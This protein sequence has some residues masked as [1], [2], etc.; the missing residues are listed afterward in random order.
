M[1]NVCIGLFDSVLRIPTAAIDWAVLLTQLV[2]AGVIDLSN[3]TE[4][5]TTLQDML[6]TLLHATLIMDGQSDRGEESRKYH[7]IL[8][9]KLKKE[10]AERKS[11]PSILCIKQLLPLP[12]LTSEFVTCE[13][14][15]TLTD[16]KGNKISGFDSNDKKQGH[17]LHD[18]QRVSPWEILE[19]HKTAAPLSW[20]WFGAVRI[21]RKPLRYQE[22]Q[23]LQRHHTHAMQKPASYFL[24]HPVL[25]PEELEPPIMLDNKVMAM[26]QPKEEISTLFK[27]ELPPTDQSPR[28]GNKRGQKTNQRRPRGRR[29]AAAAAAAAAA[30]G[31]PQPVILGF[32]CLAAFF[33]NSP[34]YNHYYDDLVFFS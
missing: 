28:G 27:M 34:I 18:K 12:K 21:E 25:P 3:N 6:A 8:I 31:Q 23:R 17:R 29:G 2:T 30:M 11:S 1:R 15:G 20:A 9:K 7:P 32:V 33:H 22:V 10:L 4:L 24:E 13:P 14:Y 16:T 5:F 26:H 19:G